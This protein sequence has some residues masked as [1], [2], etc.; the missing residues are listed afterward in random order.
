ME[1]FSDIE[2]KGTSK[3]ALN[4][5]NTLLIQLV[6]VGLGLLLFL[7]GLGSVH[8]FDWDEINFAESAREMILTGNYLDVQINFETFWEKPPLFIW[9]QVLSM[10]IF[11]INEFAA[12]FPS[13]IAGIIAL[14]VLFNVGKRLKNTTF[15]LLWAAMYLCSLFPFFFFKS[16]II[17]PWFNLFIFLG[18]YYFIGYTSIPKGG[19]PLKLVFL[20]AL[21]LGLAVL[22]KGPVGFLIFLLTFGVYLLINKFK[23]DYKWMHV[24]VFTVVFAVVG[25]FWFILQIAAGHWSIIQDFIVYQ[26]RLFQTKD[27]GHGGFLG[28]HFVMIFIGVFPASVIA[29]PTFRRSVLRNET[30]GKVKHFFRWMMSLFWVVLI[31]FTIVKT[32]IV[33]YASMTYYPLTFLGAWYVYKLVS[34]KKT[35]PA[36]VRILILVMSIIYGAAVI[37]IPYIDKFKSAL[38]PYIKDEFAVGNLEATSTWYGFEPI[39]G[40]VLIVLAVLFFVYSKKSLTLKTVSLILLGS[41]FYIS[42]TMF[43]VVPQVEKYSQA[44]AIEFYKSKIG[45]DCYIKPAFKSYAHYFYSERKPENKLDDFDFLAMEKLDKPCYFVVK[46]T[47]KAVKDFT[48]KAPDAEKL[49]DKN[50][51]VFYV[52]K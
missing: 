49:Y 44:A 27:A 45:E 26:I 17:D 6:I 3:F 33:H 38:I 34:E 19:N 16:G 41:L 42:A 32:K 37:A 13:A 40:V 10:K 51:F 43:F 28:Y 7:P 30:D 1:H 21:F 36:F 47:Q 14:L 39:I 20:S 9:M 24:L 8:L 35:V 18:I 12:R 23:L 4:S 25:G 50:G 11:G 31:L 46:N 15:G 2:N 52:R 5:V 22:T 48:E 29:L